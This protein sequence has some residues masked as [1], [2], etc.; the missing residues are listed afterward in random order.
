MVGGMAVGCGTVPTFTLAEKLA[1]L[2]AAQAKLMARIA[3]ETS[4]TMPERSAPGSTAGGDSERLRG[5]PAIGRGCGGGAMR[6]TDPL[7]ALLAKERRSP[8]RR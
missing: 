6:G 1:A 5:L 7:R 4:A 3:L 8:R 2:E